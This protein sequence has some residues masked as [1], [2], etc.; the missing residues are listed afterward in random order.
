MTHNNNRNYYQFQVSGKGMNDDTCIGWMFMVYDF[1]TKKIDTLNDW[2]GY[3]EIQFNA[4]GRYK[5]YCKLWNTCEKCDTGLAY[6]V[7]LIIFPKS[8]YYSKM[9]YCDSVVGEMTLATTNTKDT[10]WKYYLYVYNGPEL[11]S[12]NDRAWDTMTDAQIYNYYSFNDKDLIHFQ[13]NRV[14]KYKFPK[15]GKYLI[16]AQW[17]NSCLNQDTIIFSRYNIK[18]DSNITG[19]K[20][21][22]KN[23]D[24]KVIGYYDMI[25][26]K[27][28]YMELNT[29][30]IVIYSNGKRQK[31]MRTK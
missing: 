7:E 26:R 19:V 31:I 23:E 30:Y 4:K 25:G 9:I 11:D 8:K 17:W 10:C 20:N 5:V 15:K 1:Q 14:L 6:T 21:I 3:T 29:P 13:D 22:V 16:I 27:V 18:C 2:R 28:D 12:I 24:V